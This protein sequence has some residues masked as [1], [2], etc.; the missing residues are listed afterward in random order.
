MNNTM[1]PQE[2]LQLLSSALEPQAQGQISRAGYI[3]IQKALE[4]I[5][6]ALNPKPESSDATND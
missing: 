6:E 2:A 5:A 1:T 3:S 4:V